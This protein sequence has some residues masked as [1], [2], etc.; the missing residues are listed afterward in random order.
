MAVSIIVIRFK[1]IKWN[2][3]A[4]VLMVFML[5]S[6]CPTLY[7]Y[8]KTGLIVENRSSYDARIESL[9]KIT[10]TDRTTTPKKRSYQYF[11]HKIDAIII[12]SGLSKTLNIPDGYYGIEICDG[13]FCTY[14]NFRFKKAILLIIEDEKGKGRVSYRFRN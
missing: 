10:F 11:I 8:G 13:V 6:G 5:A 3:L 14:T 4:S 9:R 2:T 12:T 1:V 7:L